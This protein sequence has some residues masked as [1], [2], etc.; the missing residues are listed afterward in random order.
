M[1][2][3]RCWVCGFKQKFKTVKDARACARLHMGLTP[4]IMVFGYSDKKYQ[5]ALKNDSWG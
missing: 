5:E 3:C 4:H 1:V 2:V